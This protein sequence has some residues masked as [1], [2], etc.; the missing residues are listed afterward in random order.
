MRRQRNAKIIATLGPASSSYE[1][2]RVLYEAGADVFRLNFSHG[3]HEDHMVRFHAIR[4]LESEVQR[5]VGVLMDL[6]GPKL[7]I[8][9]F[10]DGAVTLKAG[11]DFRLDMDEGP[12]DQT[13]VAMFHPEIYRSL[14]PGAVLLLDDGRI[15]LQVSRCGDDFA[16]TNIIVGGG[17]SD[18]K[19]V[20]VSGVSLPIAALTEKDREDLAFGLGLG[21]DWVALSFVQRA[22][23]VSEIREIVNGR[24]SVLSKLEKPE[25]IKEL[26]KIVELSDA[27]M[28]ARGDL[29]VEL[30]PE[31]VP[32][33]Q[34]NIVRACRRIGKP[35]VVA[36]QMLESMVSAP[37][38]TRAE[39]T[40]VATAIYDGVDAVML[41]AESAAGAY[42]LEAVAMMDRIIC[43]TEQDP[44]Y[45]DLI[46]SGDIQPTRDVSG[47]ICAAMNCAASVIPLAATV[48]Y[49]ESGATARRA[50][51]ERPRSPILGITPCMG[52]AR[53]LQLVWGVHPSTAEAA[54]S[55]HVMEGTARDLA[56]SEGFADEGDHILIIAGLPFGKS[57]STNLIRITKIR[58]NSL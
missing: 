42:P 23:D 6:Q 11:R 55:V 38:P 48:T 4:K 8:G 52:T 43:R 34:K 16:D 9:C 12:G 40:D 56:V 32:R 57:G 17:L 7:R 18:H 47:A 28:V 20:N 24:A 1:R 51:R 44:H 49:T 30:P 13:R 29:G 37:T 58:A 25:A 31:D 15:R 41:S 2:I 50:A 10:T 53:E 5:P 45:R 54:D 22:Q 21:V 27:I 33:I 36:T 3:S 35:V 14:I 39:T 46:D 19:G 26:E